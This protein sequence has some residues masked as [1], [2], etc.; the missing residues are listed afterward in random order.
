MNLKSSFWYA[1]KI[2]NPP[3]GKNTSGR[4]S[5]LGA[6]FCIA[7]SLVPL[8]VV[9]TVADGMIEGITARMVGL[10]SY[11]AA[12]YLLTPFSDYSTEGQISQLENTRESLEKHSFVKGAFIEASGTAL[13]AGKNGRSGAQIRAVNSRLFTENTAFLRYIK[14]IEGSASF[15]ELNSA[16][17][18]KKIAEDLGVHVGDSIRLIGAKTTTEGRVIPKIKIFKISGI[19][20]SGYEELDALW[21]FVPLASGMTFLSGSSTQF[22]IGLEVDGAFTNNF[23]LEISQIKQELPNNWT[24]YTWNELNS[25]QY[26]NFSSTRILLLFIMFLIL[27]VASVNISSAIVM[28]VMER[29]SEIAILKSIGASPS[30]ITSSFIICGTLCGLGGVVIGLPLGLLCAINVNGILN[31]IQKTVNVCAKI[32]YLLV[33]K[34]DYIP[35]ELLNP[36]YYLDS[37]P[38]HI[39]FAELYAIAIGTICL[40]MIVSL[41]PSVHA[42]QEKPLSIFRKM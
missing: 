41:L 5:L 14:I 19:V 22:K 13:A 15:P 3:T 4:R 27:L 23:A 33:G 24:L 30:G 16:V 9:Q 37:I 26:E 31:F 21:V 8:V 7:L 42:G 39:P 34:T 2:L 10:S 17:I 1:I 18:G 28:V 36:A 35:V 12:A 11:H 38:V 40:S 32:L 29:R 25:S 20:S 6:V